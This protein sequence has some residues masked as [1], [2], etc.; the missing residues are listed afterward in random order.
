[1]NVYVPENLDSVMLSLSERKTKESARY[2]EIRNLKK[3]D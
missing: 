1:M 2:S 3:L